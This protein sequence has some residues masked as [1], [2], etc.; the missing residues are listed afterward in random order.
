[1]AT[2]FIKR[3]PHS[4][5]LSQPPFCFCLEPAVEIP[6]RNYGIIYECHYTDVN[7]WFR[8]QQQELQN[9]CTT[10]TITTTTTFSHDHA[11]RLQSE[12]S[13]LSSV[14]SSDKGKVLK[15]KRVASVEVALENIIRTLRTMHLVNNTSCLTTAPTPARVPTSVTATAATG[16]RQNTAVITGAGTSTRSACTH[17]GSKEV[18][19]LV[20]KFHMHSNI[21]ERF[22]DLFYQHT[23][24][25]DGDQASFLNNNKD[26]DDY[27]DASII[28]KH[29]LMLVQ[30]HHEIVM[31]CP[32]ILRNQLCHI[33]KV[34][35]KKG[36]GIARTTHCELNI[37]TVDR[38]THQGE[39]VD[40]GKESGKWV[41]WQTSEPVHALNVMEDGREILAD[42]HAHQPSQVDKVSDRE[43]NMFCRAVAVLADTSS[44]DEYDSPD[45]CCLD[46]SEAESEDDDE[47]DD[48][49][50]EEGKESWDNNVT[51]PSITT[52]WR[53]AP[54]P[55]PAGLKETRE[56][57]VVRENGSG[58]G[59]N[60][61]RE[62]CF[63]GSC[64]ERAPVLSVSKPTTARAQLKRVVNGVCTKYASTAAAG[65][66]YFRESTA[67]SWH[68]HD[69]WTGPVTLSPSTLECSWEEH[70]K[71][72]YSCSSND[73]LLRAPIG[74]LSSTFTLSTQ[75]DRLVEDVEDANLLMEPQAAMVSSHL[76]DLE[77][78]LRRW[79]DSSARLK[80]E[81][82]LRTMKG[83]DSPTLRCR[84]CKEGQLKNA[85]LPCFHLTMCMH[86]IQANTHCSTCESQI[87]GTVRVYW[88]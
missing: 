59:R 39:Q 50:K 65:A 44:D 33:A 82:Q 79:Q 56:G 42:Q 48:A 53:L 45:Q 8:A 86:C 52:P 78:R 38:W 10:T 76:Q 7:R 63:L 35:E 30:R 24:V 72:S 20:C 29:G 62:L 55:L 6:T 85:V 69:S 71:E 49:T 4:R 64:L 77:A 25:N 32:F 88:G 3:D 81:V 87:E 80:Q 2:S 74:S 73:Q 43:L 28:Q 9:A 22:K 57:M 41:Q 18:G 67:P 21:W 68:D 26:D 19:T 13:S 34:E 66:E 31:R 51:L 27:D 84:V 60:T 23:L 15:D 5:P 1:M 12:F 70:I 36:K 14:P 58:Q 11:N 46:G 83:L 61:F 54:L 17:A 40:I 75:M 16:E 47:M 37:Q